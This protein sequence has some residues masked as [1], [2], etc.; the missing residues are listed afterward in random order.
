MIK[1]SNSMAPRIVTWAELV[2]GLKPYIDSKSTLLDLHDLWK[3]GAPVPQRYQGEIERRILL[4]NQFE[5]WWRN[6]AAKQGLAPQ[7]TFDGVIYNPKGE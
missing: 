3:M 7:F 5:T 2:T 4:P 6:M 1:S